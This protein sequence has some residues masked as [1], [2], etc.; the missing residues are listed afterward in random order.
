[1]T[2][3]LL[4]TSLVLLLAC[5]AMAATY[6][7]GPSSTGDGLGGDASNLMSWATWKG[8][9]RSSDSC[10]IVGMNS[11]I[12]RP[13]EAWPACLGY[14]AQ[15]LSWYDQISMTMD[16]YYPI[17]RAANGDFFVDGP[18]N[19]VSSD[20]A[21]DGTKNGIQIDPTYWHDGLDSRVPY[22]YSATYNVA[23]D[24]L[25]SP[26][27]VS[28]GQSVVLAVGVTTYVETYLATAAVLT[29]VDSLPASGSFR[30]GYV[31][32]TGRAIE[33][34]ISD[35]DTSWLPSL[36][37]SG[38]G[39]VHKDTYTDWTNVEET[40]ERLV[41]R[42]HLDHMGGQSQTVLNAA[43]QNAHRYPSYH[44]GESA[45]AL[46]ACCSDQRT[47]T[48]VIRVI[49]RGLDYI[50]MAK[51][52]CTW[53]TE[54]GLCAM[55]PAVMLFAAR[56]LQD[57]TLEEYVIG[58]I[59]DD[60]SS[61]QCYYVSESQCWESPYYLNAYGSAYVYTTGTVTVLNGSTTVQ[62]SGSNW[63]ATMP[64]ENTSGTDVFF[65]GVAGDNRATDPFGRIYKVASWIDADTI[66]LTEPYDGEGGGSKSYTLANMLGYAH[67]KLSKVGENSGD[68]WY[69]Y[70]E[71][72]TS[73]I[74]LPDW[75]GQHGIVG[76]EHNE[77]PNFG[78]YA[79]GSM[80]GTY[81]YVACPQIPGNVL[82]LY[83]LGFDDEWITACG[84]RRLFD[85]ADRYVELSEQWFDDWGATAVRPSWAYTNWASMRPS[86]GNVWSAKPT[87]PTPS[88]TATGVATS[89]VLSWTEKTGTYG[90]KLY[91]GTTSPLTEDDLVGVV[92]AESYDPD[93]ATNTTYYWRT[94]YWD[95]G[96]NQVTGTEWSFTT[97]D[98]S[99][100]A[101][102]KYLMLYI[103]E[104]SG[105]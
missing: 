103:P 30:W 26:V 81:R 39:L 95:T 2:R 7:V 71:Y 79:W 12:S 15:T 4:L 76:G 87:S 18:I 90:V 67:A 38:D 54:E 43:I 14:Y 89:Q 16:A 94:D 34:N 105:T 86:Y 28:A 37:F 88:N 51:G 74:G 57:E 83:C 96:E 92:T 56:A 13:E 62:G 93:L 10:Y 44:A 52:G 17:G 8:S 33:Y 5:P 32:Y 53:A 23:D 61:A 98:G 24:M 85:Y 77:G 80:A 19:M 47:D 40:T 25:S 99:P 45:Q 29:V 100:P 50:A 60:D 20:P 49:Q 22:G 31:P 68:S 41:E 78:A 91:M 65:F 64:N 75:S 73:M 70:G 9:D 35:I 102:T 42:V 3:I 1:M 63:A 101:G 104:G 36:S 6:Y 58:L 69:D 72:V 66:E 21:W 48:L 55:R 82:A 11:T 97:D 27:S 46:L 59:G 84:D